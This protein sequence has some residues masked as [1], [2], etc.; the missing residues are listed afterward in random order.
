[1]VGTSISGSFPPMELTA[2]RDPC[3]LAQITASRTGHSGFLPQPK[4]NQSR[5]DL[6]RH[7]HSVNEIGSHYHQHPAPP[8]GKT[9]QLQS[10]A[11]RH[12]VLDSDNYQRSQHNHTSANSQG[13]HLRS[14]NSASF[15]YRQL[16]K[17]SLS[18]SHISTIH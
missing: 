5:S 7:C 9:S 16:S 13:T 10:R 15:S 4:G 6:C 2:I 12:C 11:Q 18:H 14:V 8:P 17:S 1:M 3:R